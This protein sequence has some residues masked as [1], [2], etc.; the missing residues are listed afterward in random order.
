MN[1]RSV[2]L[3]LAFA[4]L[5]LA[6]SQKQQDNAQ[7]T[8]RDLLADL[9]RT[10]DRLEAAQNKYRLANQDLDTMWLLI[11]FI[12]V[13]FMVPAFALR[14]LGVFRAADSQL[15][16]VKYVLLLAVSA[17]SFWVIGY[18]VGFG[19]TENDNRNAFIG[20]NDYI[21]VSSGSSIASRVYSVFSFRWAQALISVI[22]FATAL[23][24]RVSALG[25][26]LVTIV[27]T[28]FIYPIVA[29]WLWSRSG[30]L[31]VFNDGEAIG[32][33]GSHGALDFAGSAVVHVTGGAAAIAALVYL[34]GRKATATGPSNLTQVLFGALLTWFSFYGFTAGSTQALSGNGDMAQAALAS[35]IT[36]TVTLAA[37][38]GAI[39][40]LIL[41]KVT[42][43]SAAF[44]VFD[45]VNGL[46]AGLVSIAAGAGLM[47]VYGGFLIGFV[48]GALYVILSR[49]VEAM[50]LDD[51]VRTVS[52]HFVGGAWG[53]LAAGL[54]ARR[55]D[56]LRA[57]PM[58]AE[59][60]VRY[61][62]FYGGGAQLFGLNVLAVV[63][64]TAWAFI[65]TYLTL[66][67]LD[68]VGVLRLSERRA[69][70]GADATPAVVA[71]AGLVEAEKKEVEELET[72]V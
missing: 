14:E 27:Y 25:Y 55:E 49:V 61:G 5:A 28:T 45:I 70:K 66:L 18:G 1:I 15:T 9:G 71:E 47:E 8:A 35:K 39:G 57:Y 6:A 30:Y 3:V 50:G 58:L 2:I 48:A 16:V 60:K 33:A 32:R 17:I 68:K 43:P 52:V 4:A 51:G 56:V 40:A 67:V 62:I 38:G 26:F 7:E 13:L 41:S 69:E 31:S 23:G 36:F 11:N 10:K 34:G 42:A 53:T 65:V 54:W 24:E 21:L 46:I 29:H 59:R 72:R 44:N 20:N 64:I 63:A 37:S 19:D 12:V 22:I